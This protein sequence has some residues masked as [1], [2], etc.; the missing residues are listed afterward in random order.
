MKGGWES[1]KLENLCTH[2]MKLTK[3]IVRQMNNSLED[4]C[5][6]TH[7]DFCSISYKKLVWILK[8]ENSSVRIASLSSVLSAEGLWSNS[9]WIYSFLR[10]FSQ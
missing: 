7:E 4:S 8:L 2:V 1:A 10:L 5:T 6:K 9:F 3:R